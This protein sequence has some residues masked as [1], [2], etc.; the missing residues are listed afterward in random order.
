MKIQACIGKPLPSRCV[1]NPAFSKSSSGSSDGSSN[2]MSIHPRTK[3][4]WRKEKD[5]SRGQNLDYDS[6]MTY[7]EKTLFEILIFKYVYFLTMIDVTVKK[8]EQRIGRFFFQNWER[9]SAQNPKINW[10]EN[11]RVRIGRIASTAEA[12][13]SV[14]WAI[15][16]QSEDHKRMIPPKMMNDAK[17]ILTKVQIIFSVDWARDHYSIT[18]AGLEIVRDSY[19]RKTNISS[20]MEGVQFVSTT[21]PAKQK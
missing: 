3:S 20:S 5:P 12:S 1:Q 15:F 11:S 17:K 13:K 4:N 2:P 21:M 14:D 10:K 9:E 7:V 6:W 16:V 19:R 8:R 18:E